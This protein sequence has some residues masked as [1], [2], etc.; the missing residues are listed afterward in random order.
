MHATVHLN[1]R[2]QRVLV[3]G[4]LI[5]LNIVGLSSSPDW[6]KWIAL[7]L[8]LE[9]VATG[10]TGWCPLYWCVHRVRR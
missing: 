10:L 7:V 8:Q 3:G 9:L 1:D 2:I 5:G 4:L 6:P